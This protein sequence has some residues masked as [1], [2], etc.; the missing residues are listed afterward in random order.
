MG[1]R[2]GERGS[3]FKD[4]HGRWRGVVD[5]PKTGRPG[6][7]KRPQKTFYGDT[8]KSDSANEKELWSKVNALIYEIENNLYMNESNATLE[9]FLNEW[10]EVYTKRLQET[11]RELY[12]MYADVHIIPELGHLQIKK[13]RPI[14]L[15]DF[16]NKKLETLSGKTVGKLHTFLNRVLGDAMRNQLI[17]YNPCDGVEK[18]KA[19][20][21]KPNVCSEDDFQRLLGI[22]KGTF[23]EVAILLAGVC[24]LRRGEIFGLRL[25]DIDFKESKISVVETMVRLKGE[26]II[27]K[28]KNES[29]QRTIKVPDFV[30][31][32]ISEYLS[33]LKVVPQ[34]ICSEYLPNSYS[35]HFKALLEKNDLPPLRFH[36]LR[37]Y[38]AT[39]MLKYGISDKVAAAR[40]GHSQVQ[41]TREIYQHVLE[42]MDNTASDVIEEV[43]KGKKR[44]KQKETGN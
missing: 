15:Q 6:E 10:H 1:K 28:P 12:K 4:K 14:Q 38:N 32:T 8:S 39:I 7:P 36:D 27:K 20:K 16:Y 41:T 21:F 31:Y 5:L 33:S 30:T 2:R 22:A 13:I 9:Q 25:I 19:R 11:T 3:V 44:D 37:H 24:G 34:R 26:W 29:S 43:F 40:L 42:D 17:K 23:D 18:P 35:Q